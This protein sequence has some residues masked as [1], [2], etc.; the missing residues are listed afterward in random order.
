VRESVTNA[1]SELLGL[2]V[3]DRTFALA[4]AL[5]I[6]VFAIVMHVTGGAR[7]IAGPIFFLGFATI[8]VASTIRAAS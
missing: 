2:F 5:W 7:D 6:A 1:V 8:L 3:E 4:I